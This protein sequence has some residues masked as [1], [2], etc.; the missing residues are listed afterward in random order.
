MFGLSRKK[1]AMNDPVFG[2][3]SFVHG[4]WS[5]I[6]N[7]AT[8]GFMVSVA[9]PASGPSELQRS[10]FQNIRASLSE[11]EQRARDFMRS[12]VDP[13]V[14]LA[15][16]SVYSVEV[17][18]EDETRQRRFVLELSDA[19]ATVIHRVTFCGGDAVDYGCDD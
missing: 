14:A 2:H 13:G 11:F 9:A 12:R 17:G 15:R 1:P 5:F 19:D 18:S 8:D 10:L 16:V 6:P 4:V 7:A 3:I